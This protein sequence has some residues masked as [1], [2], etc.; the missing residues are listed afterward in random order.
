[1]CDQV[2]TTVSTEY[3][4]ES[5]YLEAIQ[6][7]PGKT[8]G[9]KHQALNCIAKK[10]IDN[11]METDDDG[12]KNVDVKSSAELPECLVPIV[13][14]EV[15]KIL[16]QPDGIVAA[17]KS[18]DAFINDRALKVKWF[19]DG[20]NEDITNSQYFNKHIFP[21]VSLTVRMR[22]IKNLAKYLMLSNKQSIAENFY[23]ELKEQYG[24][25]LVRPLC[26]ACGEDFIR[27]TTNKWIKP[28]TVSEL[29]IIYPRFPNFVFSLLRMY[30]VLYS[31][32]LPNLLIHH[33]E[34]FADIVK[35]SNSCI[36]LSRKKCQL[37]LKN[38][39]NA[40]LDDPKY[41]MPVLPL[42]LITT[43]LNKLEFHQ[44]YKKMF[45]QNQKEFCFTTLYEY[46]KYYPKKEEKINLIMSTFEDVY[47]ISLL[48]CADLISFQLLLENQ[49][50]VFVDIVKEFNLDIKP[51][52]KKSASFLK[53][54][55]IYLLNEPEIFIPLLPLASI[56]KKLNKLEF[57]QF[58]KHLFPEHYKEFCFTTYYQLLEYYPKE[59]KLNFLI[60][61]FKD[62]YGMSPLDCVDL[63]SFSLLLKNH[64][65]VFVDIVKM[66]NLNNNI[67]N[68]KFESFLKNV[69]DPFSR[70]NKIRM[71]LQSLKSI[72]RMLNKL[73]FYQFYKHLFP[74]SH[75]EL[76]LETIYG[77]LEYYPKEEKFNLLMSTFEDVY[78][79]NFFEWIGSMT[80][81]RLLEI[82]DIFVD[83]VK[84]LT[85]N[86]KLSYEK[87]K[88]FFKRVRDQLLNTPVLIIS[89][90]PLESITEK[91]NK[92]EFHQFYKQCFPQNYQDFSFT[93]FHKLLKYYPEEEKINLLLSTFE[94]VYGI[95]L[96]DYD[97]LIPRNMI[98]LL[99]LEQR[100]KI[101]KK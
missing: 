20:S 46:L 48:D 8:P 88:S 6:K 81:Q 82:H 101:A 71:P 14:L 93:T 19:F 49:P 89:L 42:K 66:F 75:R 58:Y 91:L 30:S 26:F 52:D 17:L 98:E 27:I 73:E 83:I 67:S 35:K 13:Q 79:L 60:S 3:K 97:Y 25:E 78:K 23:I 5:P 50:D 12:V 36:K 47:G 29:E 2:A 16:H 28:I 15:A 21:H 44:F 99:N 62:L 9:E 87:S 51:S 10:F 11:A 54:V 77:Y 86:T 33:A 39:R 76:Y 68:K 34:I 92:L 65:N 80:L 53:N 96:L 38:A 100:I 56:T 74:Q 69:L 84:E 7:I 61:T 22:I 63:I 59:E 94:D 31:K 72:T 45:P 95:S 70:R 24:E 55:R 90:L 43:M 4:M 1:M 18:D 57:N 85:S 37:F 32:F 40:F 64:A 41:F